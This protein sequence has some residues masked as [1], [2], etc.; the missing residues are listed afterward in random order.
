MPDKGTV[1]KRSVLFIGSLLVLAG[2]LALPS[3]VWA[4]DRFFYNLYLNPEK[5]GL[6]VFPREF[7]SPELKQVIKDLRFNPVESGEAV[8]RFGVKGEN[9]T[10]MMPKE[11]QKKH[12]IEKFLILQILTDRI[13]IMVGIYEQEFGLS[14]PTRV[15]LVGDL[16]EN[17]SK[18]LEIFRRQLQQEKQGIHWTPGRR[19]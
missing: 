13:G 11:V 14:L 7:E 18:T 2:A 16:K 4:K 1:M 9:I 19:R 8:M 3:R 5:F 10:Y 17:I 12:G 15:F 6:V